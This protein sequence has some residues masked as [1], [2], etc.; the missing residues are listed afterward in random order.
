MSE[1]SMPAG[2][3]PRGSRFWSETVAEFVLDGGSSELLVEV[4]RTLDRLDDLAASIVSEGVTVLG[5]QGQPV[6]HPGLAESRSQSLALHRLLAGLALPA[7]DGG[8]S[9]ESTTTVRARKAATARWAGHNAS[10]AIRE[11]M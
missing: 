9:V 4:C 5:S 7:E 3:G 8:A 11:R 2:L 6:L 10:R 1:L